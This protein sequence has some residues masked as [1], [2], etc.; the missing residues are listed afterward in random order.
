MTNFLKKIF[1][2]SNSQNTINNLEVSTN[3]SVFVLKYQNDEIG[4]LTFDG[5]Y[6]HF[7]YSDWFKNQSELRPLLSFPNVEKNYQSAELWTF[8]ASRV[9]SLKQPQVK[10]FIAERSYKVDFTELLSKFGK[11]TINNPYN[12][13]L[14]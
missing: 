4:L 7:N 13:S 8:F 1:A 12:L 6:W 2:I 9:P 14:I 3:N 10:E 11:T 5:V